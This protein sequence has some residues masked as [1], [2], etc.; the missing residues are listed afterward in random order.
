MTEQTN[1]KTLGQIYYGGSIVGRGECE[2]N[3]YGVRYSVGVG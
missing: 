2:V 3:H 1:E